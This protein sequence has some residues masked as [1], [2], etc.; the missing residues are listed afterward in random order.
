MIEGG[1][2]SIIDITL[3][4]CLGS[5]IEVNEREMWKELISKSLYLRSL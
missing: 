2:G 5:F 4:V 1:I 3:N